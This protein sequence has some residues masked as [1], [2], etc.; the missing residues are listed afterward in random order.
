M[1]RVLEWPSK[2]NIDIVQLLLEEPSRSVEID[3][4]IL[5][6]APNTISRAE[7]FR[8]TDA[9]LSSVLVQVSSR[10]MRVTR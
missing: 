5:Q 9:Q 1:P 4:V 2:L 8:V 6:T 7:A 3:L 10:V